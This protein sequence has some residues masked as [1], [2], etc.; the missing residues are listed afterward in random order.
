MNLHK[1]FPEDQGY[2]DSDYKEFYYNNYRS[3]TD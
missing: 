3:Y 1:E 2:K